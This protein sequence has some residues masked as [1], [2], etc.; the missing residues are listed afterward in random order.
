MTWLNQTTGWLLVYEEAYLQALCSTIPH[1]ATVVNIG[2][3]GGTSVCAILRGLQ[4]TQSVVY[5]IDIDPQAFDRETQ[6][7]IAQGFDLERVEQL[8][9]NSGRAAKQWKQQVDLVFVDGEHSYKGVEKDLRLWS[10]LVK[11]GG[12]LVCHDYGD[13]KQVETTKA[14]Y[15]WREK[16]LDWLLVGQVLYTVCFRKPNGNEEWRNGRI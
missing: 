9:V 8:E 3:G 10:K 12:L 6:A 16:H 13:P 15:D 4:N 5:S 1:R 11:P 14:I 2:A 7:L